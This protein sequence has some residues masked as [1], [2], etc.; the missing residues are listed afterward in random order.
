[1][2]Q[3]VLTSKARI[4]P[5]RS[6]LLLII[7]ELNSETEQRRRDTFDNVIKEKLGDA[8]TNPSKLPPSSFITYS[9]GDLY[10]PALHEEYEDPVHPDGTT[11]FEQPITDSWIH[12]E[13]NLPQGEEMKKVKVV[14][15]PKDGNGNIIGK[16][17]SNTILKLDIIYHGI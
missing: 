11:V 2:S 3:A 1:M 15:W 10:L 16:Y 8:M 13:L 14:S 4:V 12:A 17:E 5:Q 9:D 7:S 6:I